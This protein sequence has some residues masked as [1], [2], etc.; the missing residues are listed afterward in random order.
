MEKDL[1]SNF[2][3]D[4]YNDSLAAFRKNYSC[5]HVLLNLSD[6]W[7]QHKECG[8]IPGILLA[9]LSKAFDCLP[10][11]LII[12][13]L[14]AYGFDTNSVNLLTDYLSH[15][16]QRVKTG[17]AV[18]PWSVILKGVPQGSIMGPVIFYIFMNNVFLSDLKGDIFNYAD[19]TSVLVNG[20]SKDEVVNKLTESTK[21]IINWCN[22]NQME[23]NPAKFQAMIADE[24]TPSTINITETETIYTEISV[25]LLSETPRCKSG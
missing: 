6:T 21:E 17:G 1:S 12:S 22:T 5:Q 23:A 16:P 10:H 2:L 4:I 15:R 7:R 11:S 20:T 24:T 19:D 9:D 8:K 18:S 25:K 13:K 3:N 14:V